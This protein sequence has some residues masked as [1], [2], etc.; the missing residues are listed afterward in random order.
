MHNIRIYGIISLV[1]LFLVPFFD[2]I[3]R[4]TKALLNGRKGPSLFQT[5]YDLI[6]LFQKE[7]FVSQ[8]T[9]S[10]SKIA[11][12]VILLISA[13]FFFLVPITFEGVPINIFVLIF[14]FSIGS[15]FLALYG[16]DNATYFG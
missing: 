6:K 5:Y 10:F 2:G 16:L 13:I 4:K 3:V 1:G 14:I 11:P 8:F 7:S 9:S 15:F 12:I